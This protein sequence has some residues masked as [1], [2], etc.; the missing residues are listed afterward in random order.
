MGKCRLRV[1]GV[2]DGEVSDMGRM[3][4]RGEPSEVKVRVSDMGSLAKDR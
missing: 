3:T 4:Y 1:K 2:L